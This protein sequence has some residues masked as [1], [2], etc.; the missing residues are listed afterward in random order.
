[1]KPANLKR[2]ALP[3]ADAVSAKDDFE[4]TGV[5]ADT[6]TVKEGDLFVCMPS[7]SRDTHE[8]IDEVR[9]KGA[10]AIL[11]HNQEALKRLVE[12]EVPA[13]L[14]ETGGHRFNLLLGRLCRDLFGDP[15]SEMAVVGVTGTN[16]KT[17]TC[18]MMRD[19]LNGLGMT[20]GYLGTLG[21]KLADSERELRNTTP[22]PVELWNALHEAR[23]SGCQAFVMEASSHALYERRLAA[24]SF[25]VG[26]FTNLSQ[27]HLDYHGTMSAY[28]DAKKLLFTE[29]AA[30]G[31]KPMA[32]AINMGDETG[33]SWLPQIPMK[34]VTFGTPDSAIRVTAESVK[35]D[36]IRLSVLEGASDPVACRVPVGGTFNV[37]NAT[38]TIAGL[39]AL[40]IELENI[41]RAMDQVRP[42][43][44]R[45]ES[46]P[47]DRGI[48][49]IVDYAHTPDAIQKVLEAARQLDPP[50]VITVFG[51]GGDRDRSKRPLMAKAAS[52]ESD[53]VVL[54]SDNP[55]TE[56]PAQIMNDAEPG[57][58]GVNQ[59][60]LI[61]D[62]REAVK[63]AVE[64]AEP[65]D[66][67]VVAGK[68]HETY[69]EVGKER[70]HMDDRE[71]VR[72]A[73]ESLS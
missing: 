52:A 46:V 28:A 35:L 65:G 45:F 10:T 21:L 67:V 15:A 22:F 26:V 37:H 34:A 55:R 50:R 24:V 19:V 32:G 58:V 47:N 59:K 61:V 4:V 29:Y 53:I 71:L 57:I 27:D 33:G 8:F 25:A 16:G 38:A 13:V 3:H 23:E 70:H 1:M 17:T 51:C 11:V 60:H 43:P 39:R 18:M 6:R 56:D 30:G 48:G 63:K 31:R 12:E 62:R 9:S 49:V 68:G 2:C 54:T 7:L 44:G 36:E 64:L 20:A 5:S 66:I 73:L 42:V 41:C 40:G 69:Q 14:I 72:D